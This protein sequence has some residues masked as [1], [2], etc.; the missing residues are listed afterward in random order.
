MPVTEAGDA[1]QDLGYLVD[2]GLRPF[3]RV[4]YP[5]IDLDYS[6][7]DD[8]D[9]QVLAFRGRD[10]P[11]GP[12]ECGSDPG[13]AAD[14]SVPSRSRVTRDDVR[15]A[16]RALREGVEDLAEPVDEITRF[17]ECLYTVGVGTNPGYLYRDRAG[18]DTRRSALSFDLRGAHL[19]EMSL[20]A[21]PGEE[22]P[23]IECNEDAGG[24]Q[25]DE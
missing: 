24:V 22:P 4:H 2:E 1:D 13:E 15:Q 21:F 8:P 16:I 25:T 19:P 5:A 10:R 3:E 23:Q 7:W 6:E 14:R 11:F 20:M 12:G 9:Y 17:D 18:V